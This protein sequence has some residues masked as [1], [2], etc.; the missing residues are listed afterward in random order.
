MIWRAVGHALSSFA[1]RKN[2]LSRSERR[3]YF[4]SVSGFFSG[5]TGIVGGAGFTSGGFTSG[6]LM[7]GGGAALTDHPF[8]IAERDVQLPLDAKRIGE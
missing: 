7:V 5:G 1:P 6:G 2:A 3:H 4:F 8:D